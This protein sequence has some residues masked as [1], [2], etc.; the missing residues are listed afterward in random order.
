MRKKKRIKYKNENPYKPI[1]RI[2]IYI[3]ICK[4]VIIRFMI[5]R[6][7]R[8]VRPGHGVIV[9]RVYARGTTALLPGGG[10][11]A[12][13]PGGTDAAEEIKDDDNLRYYDSNNINTMTD[14][15]TRAT[16]QSITHGFR[17]RNSGSGGVARRR[18]C[19]PQC[20]RPASRRLWAR[21][22]SPTSRPSA[23]VYFPV[24]PTSPLDRR[25]LCHRVRLL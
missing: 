2:R 5:L 15:G 18:T 8:R 10:G 11:G 22:S 3:Y 24:C 17:P 16:T 14:D 6:D 23:L 25:I 19:F 12:G 4:K 7:P 20:P 1:I 21:S 9:A 13:W